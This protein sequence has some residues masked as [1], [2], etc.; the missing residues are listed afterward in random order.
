MLFF[1][2]SGQSVRES[3]FFG[4]DWEFALTDSLD[5]PG[6]GTQWRSVQL[7]HDWS[8]DYP[9]DEKAPSCGSGGYARCGIGWYRKRFEVLLHPGEVY[10]ALFEGIYM[11]A[12]LWLNGTWIGNHIYGYTSF[13]IPFGSLLRSGTNELLVRVDNSHQPGSRWYTGSGI[14]RNV[15][16]RRCQDVHVRT[17]GVQV[18]TPRVEDE[19]A[20]VEV[21]T[22]VLGG[23]RASR[24]RVETVLV[25]PEGRE[26]ARVCSEI[27][28]K[29]EMLAV[30]EL[31]VTGP[32]RW[33]L[34]TP[35]LYRACTR[36]FDGEK[37]MDEVETPF[38]IRE[39]AFDAVH[40]FMLNGRKV[41]LQGVCLHH[42]GGCLGAAVPREV[43]E[44]RLEKLREMGVNALRMS[45]N[46]PD[47]DLLDLADTMGFCVMDEAFDE[48]HTMKGKEFGSNTHA[49]RG[50]SEWFDTCFRA[51]M[52]AMIERDRNHPSII[53]WSIGNEVREQIMEDGWKY[54]RKLAGLCHSLNSTRPVTQACDMVKAEPEMAHED[55]LEQLDIVGVNYTDRWRERTET[56]YE[57]EKMEHPDWLLLGS[58]D[59]SVNGARGDY[60]LKTES[61]VWGR[62]AYYAKSLKAEK[63]WKFIRTRPYVMGSFMWTGIDYLGECFWPDKGAGAGVLDTCGYPKDGFYF[64]QSQW[65]KDIPVLHVFPHLNLPLEKGT[66]YPVVAYTN[67]PTVELLVDG[68]S[69][70]V[71]AYEFPNQGMTKQ[72]PHFEHPMAPITTN[73]LHL[74][75]DVAWGARELTAI[76][77]DLEG[78]EI[79]RQ[80]IRP[81]GEAVRVHL[82]A[83]RVSLPADGRSVVQL[84]ICLKDAEGRT[85]M[86][87]DRVVSL[88]VEGGTLLGMDNGLASDHTMYR[89]GQ[90]STF[91]GLAYAVVRAPRECGTIRLRLCA[92]GLPEEILEISAV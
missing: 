35:C 83:D 38:G 52:T 65:R 61:S 46:P 60:R 67:C 80:V 24:V 2:E 34:K 76:G 5:A 8:T 68:V 70:G 42:D 51:D 40:G 36:V 9:V 53:M 45:H 79:A 17:W 30:Q 64:Y 41:I 86:D 37:L 15:Y 11:N 56:F 22:S 21:R 3:V 10:S 7:P 31:T 59:I 43:W 88:Q 26:S 55:F 1:S 25:D 73:D 63:L 6:D 13:E 91:R 20:L 87:Q 57:E 81:V 47:P 71:K 75:W 58:E 85:V 72:W 16:L 19:S 84:E 77:R 92:E 69:H 82:Q 27:P 29:P 33:D 74:S 78:N 50:Y 23:H 62:T 39:L 12:D 89:A 54:A 49:S 28:G 48:W 4:F 18:T 32:R 90:R 14:T 66:V 44:R